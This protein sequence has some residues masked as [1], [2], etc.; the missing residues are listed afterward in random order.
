[1][2]FSFLT[3]VLHF[4]FHS[5][6]LSSEHSQAMITVPIWQ[7]II[8]SAKDLCGSHDSECEDRSDALLHYYQRFKETRFFQ[9]LSKVETANTSYTYFGRAF[10]S[11]ST[12][13]RDA[14]FYQNTLCRVN[15]ILS[16]RIKRLTLP[17]MKLSKAARTWKLRI[18]TS[19]TGL[20]N[21]N[22]SNLEMQV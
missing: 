4:S 10:C 12:A 8:L 1:M 9:I 3:H 2:I 13:S 22:G 6:F 16:G 11:S 21:E 18:W 7:N 20:V 19:V 17:F 14:A 15:I 5:S